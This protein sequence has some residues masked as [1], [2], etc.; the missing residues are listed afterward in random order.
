MAR[1]G[2]ACFHGDTAIK[3]SPLITPNNEKAI[4]IMTQ[5]YFEYTRSEIFPLLP[6]KITKVLEIGCG[7]GNT[8]GWLKAQKQCSWVG[9]VELY[10]DAAV[11]AREKLDA[12]YIGSIEQI[13]LPIEQGSLDLILCLDVLEHLLDP[14]TVV[15]RLQKLLLPGGALIASIP[16]VRHHSVLSPL[17]FKQQWEYTE[18]GILD[19]SHLRF[20][21]KKSAVRLI[22]SAGLKVD[23]ILATGLGRSRKSQYVNS[24][25]PSVIKSF[26]EKQYLIR[27]VKGLST[28]ES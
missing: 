21:V 12:I 3:C 9:G 8:L 28:S 17:L 26:Y 24:L 18:A 23:M 20:F 13:D 6:D 2:K 1:E 16:N 4:Q 7:T 19:R 15:C 5:K 22:E 11:K 27:G 25:I 10:P 14:W